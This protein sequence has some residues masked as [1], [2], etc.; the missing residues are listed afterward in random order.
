MTVENSDEPIEHEEVFRRG[1]DDIE[2]N[3]YC[4]IESKDKLKHV[5]D[6]PPDYLSVVQASPCTAGPSHID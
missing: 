2:A 4:N 1:R 6:K 3:I 5:E